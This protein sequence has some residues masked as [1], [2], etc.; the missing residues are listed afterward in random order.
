[1]N[2]NERDYNDRD[3]CDRECLGGCG[4]P[5]CECECPRTTDDDEAVTPARAA[6]EEG[7]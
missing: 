1:M 5:S 7:R 2:D 3:C 4:R 6:E